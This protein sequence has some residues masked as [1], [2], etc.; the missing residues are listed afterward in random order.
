MALNNQPTKTP[1][2]EQDPVVRA[3]NFDE[4]AMGYTVEMAQNEAARCLN[5]KTRPCVSGCPVNVQIPDFIARI[6]SGDFCLYKHF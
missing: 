6:V 3:G 5:C 1:M 2:P 4:V